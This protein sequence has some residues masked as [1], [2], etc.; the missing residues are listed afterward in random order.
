MKLMIS[1]LRASCAKCYHDHAQS[2]QR[3][4]LWGFVPAP[5]ALR[6][7]GSIE[8]VFSFSI[9]REKID[10]MRSVAS[11]VVP[12]W[13]QT[14]FKQNNSFRYW[15]TINETAT[16][17]RC[18]RLHRS[19][20]PSGWLP[21]NTVLLLNVTC[22]FHWG[23]AIPCLSESSDLSQTSQLRELDLCHGQWWCGWWLAQARW[24][25]KK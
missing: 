13:D 8:V 16:I 17:S 2:L 20:Q 19:V 25:T 5:N 14:K 21:Q 1:C 12:Q 6:C 23:F 15:I 11:F 22:Y 24:T 9:H 4:W 3:M 18:P 10:W 7:L